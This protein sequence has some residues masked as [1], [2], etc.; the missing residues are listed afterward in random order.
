MASP[1]RKLALPPSLHRTGSSGSS[2]SSSLT[3]P[4]SDFL[5]RRTDIRAAR[6][7]I[8]LQGPAGTTA[9]QSTLNDSPPAEATQATQQTFAIQTISRPLASP[10]GAPAPPNRVAPLAPPHQPMPNQSPGTRIHSQ[11]P[12]PG[13]VPVQGADIASITESE[14]KKENAHQDVT[15]TPYVSVWDRAVATLRDKKSENVSKIS[16]FSIFPH[17]STQHTR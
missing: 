10:I 1:P 13:G 6:A 12:I 2:G 17:I 5:T 16:N 11:P 9:P 15:E 3:L 14:A 4:P 8:E 7:A